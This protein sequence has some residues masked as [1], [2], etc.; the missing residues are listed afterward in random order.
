MSCHVAVKICGIT[1][2]DGLRA[3]ADAGA[4]AVGFVFAPGARRVSLDEAEALRAHL[5][6]SV[7]AVGVFVDWQPEPL[8]EAARRLR[9]SAIQL[10]R[11]PAL[12]WG[13]EAFEGLRA[14]AREA[15]VRLVIAVAARSA[16][17]L[18][19]ALSNADRFDRILVDAWIPGRDGGTG[20]TFDWSLTDVVKRFGKPVVVAG[21]LNPDNVG[22]AI[23]RARPWGVDVSSG[24]EA[25]PGIKHPVLVH[26]FVENARRAAAELE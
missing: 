19:Q 10:H 8:W 26:R 25:S 18:T 11:D 7:E 14:Y 15:E 23:R 20:R 21:G 2:L 6:A 9:L 24:V 1:T 5:P 12:L 22:D 16:D 3:A 17:A 13:E 4:D